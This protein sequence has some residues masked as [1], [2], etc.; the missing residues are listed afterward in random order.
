MESVA[1]V[2]D[3][4]TQK[5]ISD[6][7]PEEDI[8]TELSDFFSLFSDYTRLKIVSALSISEM[9]VTDISVVTG[10][11]QTTVSHQLRYMRG[12]GAVTPKREGKIIT[13]ALKE[14]II[15]EIL[16]KGVEFLSK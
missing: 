7:M 6:Y 11:N 15:S 4:K 12:I 3:K 8:L 1:L 14:D 10:I 9:C 2:L 13:Y 16:L 5:K